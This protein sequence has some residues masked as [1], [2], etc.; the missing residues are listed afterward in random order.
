MVGDVHDF[1]LYVLY[2]QED[3]GL[4]SY[5]GY[6]AVTRIY[7]ALSSSFSVES[8]I[9]FANYS[10]NFYRKKAFRT[11]PLGGSRLSSIPV[12]IGE[13][14]VYTALFGEPTGGTSS[15]RISGS[16]WMWMHPT[17]V[18]S[19]FN[20][21]ELIYDV[22][23]LPDT[24]DALAIALFVDYLPYWLTP[25]VDYMDG[26]DQMENGKWGTEYASAES[27]FR[28]LL[29]CEELFSMMASWFQ[30]EC[31]SANWNELGEVDIPD[32][33]PTGGTTGQ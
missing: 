23:G 15:G 12:G 5:G 27:A 2:E 22:P 25:F 17:F 11:A 30:E 1:R 28:I 10:L 24:C 3:S 6:S 16:A 32:D 20:G 33:I 29:R 26:L 31:Q 19:E 7:G 9:C 21:V 4:S 18:D 13:F 14:G 8:A